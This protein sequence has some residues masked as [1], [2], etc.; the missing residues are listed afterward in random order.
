MTQLHEP[1]ESGW[2]VIT[3]AGRIEFRWSSMAGHGTCPAHADRRRSGFG[4]SKFNHM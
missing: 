3:A 4:R 2:V 1:P